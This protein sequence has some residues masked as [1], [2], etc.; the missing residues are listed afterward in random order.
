MYFIRAIEQY[1][2]QYITMSTLYPFH[3]IRLQC[4]QAT[5]IAPPT[6]LIVH[7]WFKVLFSCSHKP[8]YPVLP[9]TIVTATKPKPHLQHLRNKH[10]HHLSKRINMRHICS[11]QRYTR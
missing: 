4:C 1:T 6:F 5:P 8:L 10:K 9:L 7:L 2:K 11:I 3:M